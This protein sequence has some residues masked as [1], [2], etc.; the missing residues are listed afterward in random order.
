MVIDTLGRMG[1]VMLCSVAPSFAELVMA[2]L[3]SMALWA[4]FGGAAVAVA[5]FYRGGLR[6]W[7]D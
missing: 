6:K 3:V 5:Y 7:L 2:D 1:V 4:A